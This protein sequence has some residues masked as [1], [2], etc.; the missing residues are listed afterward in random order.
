MQ[1]PVGVNMHQYQES[2]KEH[3]NWKRELKLKWLG[4]TIEQYGREEIVKKMNGKQKGGNQPKQKYI[5][6]PIISQTN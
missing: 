5:W 2:S 6:K 4:K 1:T 3:A